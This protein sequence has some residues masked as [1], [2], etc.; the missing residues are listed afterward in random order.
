MENQTTFIRIQIT[1]IVCTCIIIVS[2]IISNYMSTV[3]DRNNMSHNMDTAIQKGI[4]PIS[5][6]C[7]YETQ[8]NNLCVVYAL[9]AK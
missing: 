3:N 1:L 7:A 9:K 2:L 6:K 4:D 8:T 5:V